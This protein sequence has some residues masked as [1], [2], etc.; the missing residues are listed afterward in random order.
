MILLDFKNNH[1]I[2]LS[3]LSNITQIPRVTLNRD[4]NELKKAG[5]IKRIGTARAGYWEILEE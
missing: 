5:K 1:T 4:I 3:T 2:S